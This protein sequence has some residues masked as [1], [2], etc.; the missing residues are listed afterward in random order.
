LR[1]SCKS[2]ASSQSALAKECRT[3][4]RRGSAKTNLGHASV[5]SH[6][7]ADVGENVAAC[8]ARADFRLNMLPGSLWNTPCDASSTARR[9]T[10]ISSRV[11]CSSFRVASSASWAFSAAILATAAAS[12]ISGR[13]ALLARWGLVIGFYLE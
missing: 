7:R 12:A 13:L 10:P 8:L 9:V 1:Q 5:V 6:D 2:L 3:A 11:S 4:L